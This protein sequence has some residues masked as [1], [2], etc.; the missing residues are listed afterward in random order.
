[1]NEV[2]PIPTE[3]DADMK[4]IIEHLMTGKPLEPELVHRVREEGE[5]IR[6]EIYQKHGLLDIAVPLIR[7]IRGELPMP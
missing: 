7:E 6:E 4:A 2:A 1:M 5:R 3:T